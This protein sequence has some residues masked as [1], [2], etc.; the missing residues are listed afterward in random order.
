MT[1][2]RHAVRVIEALAGTYEIDLRW[3]D[4]TYPRAYIVLRLVAAPY[5]STPR[6]AI[7]A[8]H[9]IGHI[10]TWPEAYRSGPRG[11]RRWFADEGEQWRTEALCWR[12]AL[13]SKR[14]RPVTG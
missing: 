6:N 4:G 13:S 14:L 10:A 2:E 12:W 3:R 5:P 7:A 9:E 8:F 11:D 1:F